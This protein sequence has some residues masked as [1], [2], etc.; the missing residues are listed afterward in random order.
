MKKWQQAVHGT[1][2]VVMA[3]NSLPAYAQQGVAI[4]NGNDV[5]EGTVSDNACATAGAATCT[6]NALQRAIFSSVVA[7]IPAG[8]NA[9][10]TVSLGIQSYTQSVGGAGMLVNTGNASAVLH[11]CGNYAQL[12]TTN[13][14]T[15]LQIIAGASGKTIYICDF[16][17]SVSGTATNINFTIGTGTNCA[18]GSS[19]LGQTW[20]ATGTGWAKAATN[21]YYRGLSSAAVGSAALCET[22]SAT[23]TFGVGIYYDQY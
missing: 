6:I 20:Y 3:V 21:P 5:V 16:D 10:G 13:N 23:A 9:I 15:T 18:S 11:V 8:T 17:I 4:G 7:A 22:S 19:T 2:M 14:A 1:L 12:S